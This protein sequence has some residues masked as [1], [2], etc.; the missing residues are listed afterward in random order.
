[1]FPELQTIS[2]QIFRDVLVT[3]ISIKVVGLF[4]KVPILTYFPY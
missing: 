1:M 2:Q 3:P 4:I